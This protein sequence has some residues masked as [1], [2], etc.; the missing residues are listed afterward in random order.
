MKHIKISKNAREAVFTDGE[1]KFTYTKMEIDVR[2]ASETDERV[3]K[4]LEWAR[5]HMVY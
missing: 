2:L 3:I 5:K 4:L 1:D